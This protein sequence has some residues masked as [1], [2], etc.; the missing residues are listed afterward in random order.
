MNLVSATRWAYIARDSCTQCQSMDDWCTYQAR[1]INSFQNNE[2]W[3]KNPSDT[4]KPF[5]HVSSNEWSQWEQPDEDTWQ[6][7][8]TQCQSMDDWCTYQARPFNSF[9]N[10]E[11]WMK[12]PSDCFK[13]CPHVSSNE[14]IKCKQP[15]KHTLQGI[16]VHS[17]SQW[18]TGALTKP[19]LSIHS[20]AMNTG[21]RIHQT[22]SNHV[23][24]TVSMNELSESN[25]MRVHGKCIIHSV[26]QRITGAPTMPGLSIQSRTRNSGQRIYQMPSNLVLVSAAMNEVSV[27]NLM[28][29]H[30]KGFMYT[31]SVND[32]LVHFPSQAFQ[33]IPE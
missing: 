4:I 16:H 10:M 7:H 30:C 12:N 24:M 29:M 31:V 5:P 33:F 19:G 27:S 20:K 11:Y 18:K 1:P 26:S 3:S 2:Y 13:P 25:Q 9:L 22:P 21:Q 32:R 8:H 23:F 14:W 28:R 6:A 17:V 15:D